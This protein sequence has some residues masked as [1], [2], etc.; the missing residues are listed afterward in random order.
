MKIINPEIQAYASAFFE[1]ENS[2]LLCS[3][4]FMFW[5][6]NGFYLSNVPENETKHQLKSAHEF[7]INGII[8]VIRRKIILS[9]CL[10]LSGLI[11]Y[12]IIAVI[13]NIIFDFTVLQ[14][15]TGSGCSLP[16]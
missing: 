14:G 2:S 10:I 4:D 9:Y 13:E 6:L 7:W 16:F 11:C 1:L 3:F 15:K 12:V 5:Y 8:K